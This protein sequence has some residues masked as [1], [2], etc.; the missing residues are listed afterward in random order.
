M[1]NSYQQKIEKWL[2]YLNLSIKYIIFK[3]NV[4]TRTTQTPQGSSKNQEVI[5]LG[6]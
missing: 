5:G 6:H 4:I 2:Y 1:I 3:E